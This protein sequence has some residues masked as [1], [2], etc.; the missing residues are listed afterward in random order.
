MGEQMT[1]DTKARLAGILAR[2]K[3]LR[4]EKNKQQHD[5]EVT[6]ASIGKAWNEKIENVLLPGL[7]GVAKMFDEAGWFFETTKGP[8]GFKIS[9]YRG[10]MRAYNGRERPYLSFELPK[11]HDTVVMAVGL[12]NSITPAAADFSVDVLGVETLTELVTSFAEKLAL[13]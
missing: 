7:S 1:D 13:K 9:I 8:R 3:E 6:M 2:D 4:A 11:D 12:P 10:D 5:K